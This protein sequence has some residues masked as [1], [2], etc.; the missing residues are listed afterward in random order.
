MRAA[1][2]ATA[3]TPHKSPPPSWI[4]LAAVLLAPLSGLLFFTVVAPPG[5]PKA[6]VVASYLS[7]KLCFTRF[8]ADES[9]GS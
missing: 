3:N 8:C 6:P 4:A 7:Y 5:N 1:S 2:M 9:P